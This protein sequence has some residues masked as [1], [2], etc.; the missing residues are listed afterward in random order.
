MS[1]G[2]RRWRSALLFALVAAGLLWEVWKW[3]EVLRYR[4]TMARVEAE[5]EKGLLSLAAKD[6]AELLAGNPGSDEVAFLLGSCEKGRGRT[7]AA[8]DAWA[9]VSPDSAF[10]FRALESRVELEFEQG[11]LTEA[12][13]LIMRTREGPRIVDPDPTILLGSIYC[14]QG[15]VEEAK[16]LIEALWRRHNDSGAAASETAINQLRLYVQLQSKPVP[17]RKSVV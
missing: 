10:A 11:R 12:E 16:Q 5:M 4:Q 6:L 1:Q 14:R 2:A 9:K 13:Q 17:D 7:R 8:A 3:S 15:R